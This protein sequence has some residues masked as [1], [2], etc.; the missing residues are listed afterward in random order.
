MATKPETRAVAAKLSLEQL[1]R[2][3]EV[4][5]EKKRFADDAFRLIMYAPEGLYRDQNALRKKVWEDA[6]DARDAVLG[7]RELLAER[8][9][10]A[11]K[12]TTPT[13]AP[14]DDTPC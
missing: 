1:E 8:K 11:L 9:L 12:P 4:C 5:L 7:A 10:L 13:D 14:P 2:L 6:L 3:L